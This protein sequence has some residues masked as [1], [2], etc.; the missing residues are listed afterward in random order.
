MGYDEKKKKKDNDGDNEYDNEN[1]NENSKQRSGSVTEDDDL[2][3]GSSEDLVLTQSKLS[4]SSSE[5]Q[6]PVVP[7]D[8]ETVEHWSDDNQEQESEATFIP[9]FA[10]SIITFA[11]S[12]FSMSFYRFFGFHSEQTKETSSG[13][14]VMMLVIFLNITGD[15]KRNS[16]L[17]SAFILL[18]LFHSFHP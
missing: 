8:Q 13:V 2:E 14:G 4:S 7:V 3:D 9:R 5:I 11:S 1:K 17:Q 15:R 16:D 6:V 18:S 12:I 10:M